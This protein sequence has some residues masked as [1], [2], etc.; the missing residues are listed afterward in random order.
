MSEHPG[1]EVSPDIQ[2]Q[3]ELPLAIVKGRSLD[4]LPHDLYIPPDALQVFLEAFRAGAARTGY[5]GDYS[6]HDDSG[7]Q[8]FGSPLSGSLSNRQSTSRLPTRRRPESPASTARAPISSKG[9]WQGVTR[10]R[11]PMGARPA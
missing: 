3:E 4:S 6:R 7:S 1:Q 9:P 2:R 5:R 11:R 8:R 10:C